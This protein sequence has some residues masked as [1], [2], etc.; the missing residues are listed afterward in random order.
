MSGEW[1]LVPPGFRFGVEIIH[2]PHTKNRD[3]REQAPDGSI[4]LTV[5]E[6]GHMCSMLEEM[7]NGGVDHTREILVLWEL[8]QQAPMTQVT[9]EELAEESEL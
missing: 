7:R 4:H 9:H 8:L 5:E 3:R 1:L 2:R 6:H